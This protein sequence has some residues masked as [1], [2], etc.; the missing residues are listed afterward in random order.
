M[1]EQMA[2]AMLMIVVLGLMAV[3]SSLP[4]NHEIKFLR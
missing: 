4:A 2:E 3:G 1:E